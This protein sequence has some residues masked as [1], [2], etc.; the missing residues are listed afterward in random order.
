MLIWALIF[1]ELDYVGLTAH[2]TP[3][4][5]PRLKSWMVVELSGG[6]RRPIKSKK[7]KAICKQEKVRVRDFTFCI[8]FCEIGASLKGSVYMWLGEYFLE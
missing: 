4:L 8:I 5:T 6:Y 7:K 3:Y 1:A 2:G